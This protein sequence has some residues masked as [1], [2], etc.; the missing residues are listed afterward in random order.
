MS[1]ASE[2]TDYYR[3]E[4]EVTANAVV[5]LKRAGLLRADIHPTEIFCAVG[6]SND[7]LR[8]AIARAERV[9]AARLRPQAEVYTRPVA[10]AALPVVRDDNRRLGRDPE[11]SVAVGGAPQG[12]IVPDDSRAPTSPGRVAGT[13]VAIPPAAPRRTYTDAGRRRAAEAIFAEWR[14]TGNLDCTRCGEAIADGETAVVMSARHQ[15]CT[16]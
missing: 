2:V 3:T 14:V 9:P 6:I 8:L 1:I 15:G 7:D 11:S 4:V 16:P 5:A 10:P 13:V 12:A